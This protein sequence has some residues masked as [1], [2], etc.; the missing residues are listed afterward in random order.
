M[1][2]WYTKYANKALDAD[3]S[4][5]NANYAKAYHLLQKAYGGQQTLI[6]DVLL[7]FRSFAK[8]R[9]KVPKASRRTF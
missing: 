2:D 7:R 3:T 5:V 9:V 1:D 4:I 8:V 6:E